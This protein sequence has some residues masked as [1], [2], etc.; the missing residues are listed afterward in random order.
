MKEDSDAGEEGKWEKRRKE[1][2]RY[3]MDNEWCYITLGG[4]IAAELIEVA[5]IINRLYLE[6]KYE[7]SRKCDFLNIVYVTK[8]L[9]NLESAIAISGV[10]IRFISLRYF[11][12]HIVAILWTEKISDKQ[13]IWHT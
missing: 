6:L 12:V 4:P 2:S 8:Y 9:I 3:I 11:T 10:I 7:W 5:K 1:A 13:Q